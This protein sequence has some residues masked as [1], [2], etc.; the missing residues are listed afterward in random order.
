MQILFSTKT[1]KC[2]K[3]FQVFLFHFNHFSLLISNWRQKMLSLLIKKKKRTDDLRKLSAQN[4]FSFADLFGHA[5][6]LE[7]C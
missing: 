5:S 2:F 3:D 4:M 7:V 6:K 1:C